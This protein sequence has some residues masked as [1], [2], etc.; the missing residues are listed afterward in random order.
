MHVRHFIETKGNLQQKS[1]A[2]NAH[3]HNIC[4]LVKVN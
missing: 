3:K 2:S 4:M 1:K